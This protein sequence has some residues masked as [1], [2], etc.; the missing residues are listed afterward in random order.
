M[1]KKLTER[2]KK[3][4]LELIDAICKIYGVED[5][6]FGATTKDGKGWFSSASYNLEKRPDSRI[7]KIVDAVNEMDGINGN[8]IEEGSKRAAEFIDDFLKND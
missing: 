7:V 3:Q 6:Y 4:C 8:W 5:Y 1:S 2:G